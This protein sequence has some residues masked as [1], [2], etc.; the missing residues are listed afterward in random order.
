[1]RVIACRKCAENLY[2]V[3]EL[4]KLGVEVFYTGEFLTNWL[5]SG[6]RVL[7]I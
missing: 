3:E 2:V 5:K 7:T 6:E 1:V 4:E